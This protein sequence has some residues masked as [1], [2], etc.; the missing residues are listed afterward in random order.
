MFRQRVMINNPYAGNLGRWS[1]DSLNTMYTRSVVRGPCT[2]KAYDQIMHQHK[3]FKCRCE[4]M[5]NASY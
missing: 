5:E 4:S 2:R 3:S 1:T